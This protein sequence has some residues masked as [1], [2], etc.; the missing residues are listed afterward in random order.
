MT[1]LS[2]LH[3]P[4]VLPICMP[5]SDAIVFNKFI[6]RTQMSIEA[7]QLVPESKPSA[8]ELRELRA[9]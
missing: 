8:E 7:N 1:G 5:S 4:S 6:F 2:L 9:E 3:M